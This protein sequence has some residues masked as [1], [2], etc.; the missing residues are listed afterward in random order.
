MEKGY[1]FGYGKG[2]YD[3]GFVFLEGN[4]KRGK[5]NGEKCKIFSDK[6]VLIF[7]GGMNNGIPD[8]HCKEF[9]EKGKV[10]TMGNFSMGK[11]IGGNPM[12]TKRG[13]NYSSINTPKRLDK[14]NSR[15]NPFTKKIRN[16]TPGKGELRM[17]K[18]PCLVESQFITNID[19]YNYNNKYGESDLLKTEQ[20]YPKERNLNKRSNTIDYGDICSGG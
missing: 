13:R 12:N 5:L 2:F 1:Y 4:F 8:G 11:L 14:Y 16:S 17:N 7:Q 20:N 19:A 9:N 3:N 15:L 18:E 6:G 10:I